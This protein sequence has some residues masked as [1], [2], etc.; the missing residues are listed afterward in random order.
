MAVIIRCSLLSVRFEE[1]RNAN[2]C[3]ALVT[4]CTLVAKHPARVEPQPPVKSKEL[5]FCIVYIVGFLPVMLANVK[6]LESLPDSFA[7]CTRIVPRLTL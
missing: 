3:S 6:S 7:S 5:A 4:A 2:Y 1:L